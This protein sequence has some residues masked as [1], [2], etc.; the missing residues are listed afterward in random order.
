[1]SG[2]K[3]CRK[4]RPKLKPSTSVVTR[5]DKDFSVGTL[6]CRTL[7][8][9]IKLIDTAMEAKRLNL[10]IL[11]VQE[12]KLKGTGDVD[13]GKSSNNLKNWR[14]MYSGFDTAY[15]GTGQLINPTSVTLLDDSIVQKEEYTHLN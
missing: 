3:S 5:K 13:L 11:A 8:N 10:D 1:M 7:T 12:H 2:P 6:N 4:K 14:F 15:G 9:E